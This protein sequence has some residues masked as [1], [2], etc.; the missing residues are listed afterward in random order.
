MLVNEKHFFPE[1]S[2]VWMQTLDFLEG[3]GGK[4]GLSV[5]Q[6]H[7]IEFWMYTLP[8]I[9]AETYEPLD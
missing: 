7:M 8:S 3:T 6:S 9:V 5:G 1:N 4:V 2:G